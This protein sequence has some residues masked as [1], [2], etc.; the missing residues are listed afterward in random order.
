M[1]GRGEARLDRTFLIALVLAGTSLSS[2]LVLERFPVLDPNGLVR[3]T[4][5]LLVVLSG[6][7]VV[8]HAAGRLFER[9]VARVWTQ[10]KARSAWK[11]ISYVLW[12]IIVVA[13]VFGIMGDV[14]TTALSLGIVGAAIA[15]ILQRPLQNLAGWAIITSRQV[16]QIGDRIAL[17]GVRGYVTDIGLMYTELQEFGEWMHGDTFTGRIVTVPNA[18]VIDG[19]VYNYTRDFPFV[20]DEIETLITYE[21]DIDAAKNHM[22]SAAMQVVGG[23]MAENFEKYRD[24]LTL[25]DLGKS[26]PKIP[27]IRMEFADSGVKLYALYFCPVEIRRKIKAEMTEAVWRR[28]SE[29]PRVGIAY[30][31]LQIVA[32]DED[33]AAA[34]RLTK[35][36]PVP[37]P[38]A[39]S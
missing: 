33:K 28:F 17:G 37:N 14:A 15:F 20:W 31:H 22:L 24:N 2:L 32:A 30:P 12:G 29:D 7:W 3:T 23:T 16:Y 19:P 36:V 1:Q 27:E 5:L 13:L 38:R 6:M 39:H 4:V 9:M 8:L 21:S 25:Q 11:V 35:V 26:L 34:R 10:A 18:V